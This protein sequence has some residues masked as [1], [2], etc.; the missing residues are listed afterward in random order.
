MQDGV[1]LAARTTAWLAVLIGMLVA[2]TNLHGYLREQQSLKA[3]LRRLL[4]HGRVETRDDLIRLKRFLSERISYDISKRD[5]WRPLLRQS[6]ATTLTRGVGFC[7]E[8]AR[9]A[10]R[11]LNLGGVR[12]NRI[13]LRGPRWSH[14]LVEHDWESGLR[15]FDG[16]SDPGTLLRD[17][18]VGRIS[19]GDFERLPNAYRD[20]NPWIASFR[21]KL[22]KRPGFWRALSQYRA[23]R[24]IVAVAESPD[25]VRALAGF[26]L[27]C[28][29]LLAASAL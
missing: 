3:L 24:L 20:L 28:A 1:T 23:P 19:P 2:A 5:D 13:Y 14:V 25:L 9:V 6:A 10:I 15:L 22:P 26:A 8:N 7:G 16:H 17:E 12:A 29:G 18:D 21:I 4:E 11:L 27:L